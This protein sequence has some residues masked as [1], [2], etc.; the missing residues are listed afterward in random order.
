MKA[1]SFTKSPYLCLFKLGHDMLALLS[2]DRYI[3]SGEKLAGVYSTTRRGRDQNTTQVDNRQGR[4]GTLYLRLL[5]LTPCGQASIFELFWEAAERSGQVR[6]GQVRSG[7]VRSGQV[8]SIHVKSQVKSSQVR[9]QDVYIFQFRWWYSYT[10]LHSCL[11]L[12]TNLCL[13]GANETTFSNKKDW[14]WGC[15][16]RESHY[17]SI[18]PCCGKRTLL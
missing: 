7:Q 3:L 1:S 14:N 4:A 5:H 15:Q 11:L 13:H 9:P 17:A 10:V 2:G 6:S 16:P 18:F 12:L 8:R